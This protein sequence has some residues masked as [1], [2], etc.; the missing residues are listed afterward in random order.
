MQK[1]IISICCL[2]HYVTPE[3]SA[4]SM[5]YDGVF[6]TLISAGYALT[7]THA[8]RYIWV[9][10]I[11]GPGPRGPHFGAPGALGAPYIF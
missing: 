3:Y 6:I 11:H 5:F 1:N 9:F 10:D 4:G 2:D 8:I 7:V